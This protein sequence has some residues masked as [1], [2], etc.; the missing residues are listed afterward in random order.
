MTHPCPTPGCD[1][2]LRREPADS[3]ADADDNRREVY[4]ACVWCEECGWVQAIE[5]GDDE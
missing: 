2:A 5:Q 1:G 3:T 4:P